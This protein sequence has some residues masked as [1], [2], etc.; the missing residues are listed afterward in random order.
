MGQPQSE[1]A[2]REAAF[3]AQVRAALATP[4]DQAEGTVGIRQ[5][6]AVEA[7]SAE[8][9]WALQD[10]MLRK[11]DDKRYTD[12]PERYWRYHARPLT[13]VAVGLLALQWW[14]PELN[15]A[16]GRPLGDWHGLVRLALLFAA[17][18][19]AFMAWPQYRH[20]EDTP[21]DRARRAKVHEDFTAG[22][23]NRLRR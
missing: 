16:A 14:L 3:E 4:P 17:A 18:G 23:T 6:N 1:P 9:F 12:P 7:A 11:S 8:N 20:V 2:A 21:E 13:V 19:A 5:A 15:E 10:A 22:L